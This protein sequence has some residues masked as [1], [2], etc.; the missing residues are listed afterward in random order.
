MID[1]KSILKFMTCGSVDDGKSTLLGRLLFE[2]KNIYNDQLLQLY[3]K[4]NN[5]KKIDFSRLLDGLVSE[6]EQGIT[7]DIAYRF[8]STYKRSFIIADSPGHIQYTRNMV[9]AASNVDLAIILIDAKKGISNQ[10]KRHSFICNLLGIKNLILAVNKMDLINYS[11]SKYLKI[12]KEYTLFANK[13]GI[14]K[15]VSVPVSALLGDNLKSK[16]KKMIWYKGKSLFKI[17]ENTE[18]E[19]DLE[20]NDSFL[21]PV[22]LVNRSFSNKRIFAGKII[23]GRIRKN[24]KIFIYPTKTQTTVSEVFTLGKKTQSKLKDSIKLSFKDEVDC[25]RGDVITVEKSN[26]KISDQFD[27]TLIWMDSSHLISGREYWLKIGTKVTVA[28]IQRVK[29]VIDIEDLKE[30]SSEKLILNDIG[31]CVMLTNEIIAYTSYTENRD[32]GSFIL[33]DKESNNTVA[34]GLINFALKR[35]ENIF[36]Q[37][38]SVDKNSRSKIKNQKPMVLWLTGISGAGKT[39]I[40]NLLEKKF[41]A[42]NYHTFLLD[43]DNVRLG[44]NK[45]LGFTTSDRAENIRRIS[46]VAKLMNEAGLIVITAFISP[47][48]TERQMA[49]NIIGKNNFIEIFINTSLKEA[50]KRDSKGLYKKARKGIIKNFT[51][52][53]S[54][55]EEPKKPL[56]KINTSNTS[57]NEAADFIFKYVLKRLTK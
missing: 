32:L 5:I 37:K 50:E 48:S 11:Q 36:F 35:S 17:L 1:K 18:I 57:P 39:T 6:R 55:Y 7:I 56:L 22:Q 28:R 3:S 40:A 46:E 34:A 2:S 47:F 54:D 30:L 43:G 29:S 33:I 19:S 23:Q 12:L 16:S 15:F 20:S 52:I 4:K 27:I 21:M 8:F 14:K 25:S 44:L 31:N 38:T 13:T 10:T 49:K 41:I 53:D 26:L 45:D 9:T 24:D 42:R 51:G